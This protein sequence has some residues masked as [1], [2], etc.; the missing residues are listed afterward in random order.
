MNKLIKSILNGILNTLFSIITSPT[1]KANIITSV[2]KLLFCKSNSLE[3]DPSFKEYWLK[4]NNEYLFIVK[5]PYYNFSKENLYKS[6][7]D[8]YCK[9]YLVKRGDIIVDVGA[10]IGTETLF[11][12][13]KIGQKGK[14]YSIE[15]STDSFN[16]LNAL[17]AKNKIEN[18][19]NFN[20]A[21][22]NFNGKIWMEET[23]KFE[24]NQ[25]NT[26]NKGIEIECFTMDQFVLNNNISRI[27]LLKVNIEGA[28]KQ[29]IDGMNNSIKIINN[30][31]ISCH[32]FLFNED[33]QIMTKV[34]TFLECNNFKV[35]Y[36]KTGNKV[37]DSWIY[38]KRK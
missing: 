17:C 2:S 5:N 12:Y 37:T 35:T 13:E 10:G 18:S 21:I 11:F 34:V 26:E 28:E 30:V 20:V 23:D 1:K 22:S 25:I 15:A 27:D 6:I 36:N 8:I 32:D 29:M 33:Q 31:A 3:Y 7:N 19:H 24:V 9:N 38:G 4:N 14:I 16:K